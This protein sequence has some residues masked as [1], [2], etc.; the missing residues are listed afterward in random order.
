M[1][2]FKIFL[3]IALFLLISANFVKAGQ[4]NFTNKTNYNDLYVIW[5]G[6]FQ[7][8]AP[9][10]ERSVTLTIPANADS[11]YVMSLSQ[12]KCAHFPQVSID[13]VTKMMTDDAK[14]FLRNAISKVMSINN[15]QNYKFEITA[16]R[17]KTYPI[18]NYK[19]EYATD[20]SLSLNG[21][22]Q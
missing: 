10:N 5:L 3:N 18:P 17:C 11:F 4:I 13:P 14:Y 19:N 16:E 21:G 22:R 20:Q 2:N 1:K 9:L 6:K 7:T 12:S 8:S 15:S